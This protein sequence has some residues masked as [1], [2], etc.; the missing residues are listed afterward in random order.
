MLRNLQLL[1]F[2]AA[3]LVLVYHS[4]KVFTALGGDSDWLMA[5]AQYGG[6][7]VDIFFVISGFVIWH[8]TF[9]QAGK[10]IHCLSFVRRR[11]FRIYLGYWPYYLLAALA[12]LYIGERDPAVIDWW[13]SFFLINPTIKH[14]VLGVSW[15]LAYELYFYAL[16]TPLLLLSRNTARNLIIVMLVVVIVINKLV[17]THK[18]GI[19]IVLS[20]YLIEFFAGCLIAIFMQRMNSRVVIAALVVVMVAALF[21]AVNYA[22]RFNMGRIEGFG[23]VA[24]SLV[25]LMVLLENRGLYQAGRWLTFLGDSSYSLYLSHFIVITLLMSFLKGV[26]LAL[27]QPLVWIIYWAFLLFIIAISALNYHYIE[28]PLYRYALKYWPS[29]ALRQRLK[30]VPKPV[31]NK[32]E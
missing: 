19:G 11:L 23:V 5:V 28:R 7:G 25:A 27:G 13:R 21:Y 29:P 15:S 18:L 2:I 31:G 12:L 26:D 4:R 16:F 17:L 10:S 30:G 9:G 20:P 14:Q 22:S 3:F 24:I 8:T 1:R 6:F 32:P